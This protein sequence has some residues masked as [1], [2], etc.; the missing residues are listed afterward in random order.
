M[1][2]ARSVSA[3]ANAEK[4]EDVAPSCSTTNVIVLD[5]EQVTLMLS[6]KV[7]AQRYDIIT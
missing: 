2:S 3:R 5:D 7:F 6:R 1:G 4:D